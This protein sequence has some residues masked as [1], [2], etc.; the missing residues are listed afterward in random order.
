MVPIV[1]DLLAGGVINYPKNDRF[2]H[3]QVLPSSSVCYLPANPKML[4]ITP[5]ETSFTSLVGTAAAIFSHSTPL[6]LLMLPLSALVRRQTFEYFIYKLK[7][8]WIQQLNLFATL[9]QDVVDRSLTWLI[10]IFIMSTSYEK[11]TLVY[12]KERK[13]RRTQWG[14]I[15]S[16][17]S[18][19]N[20][21][22]LC[23]WIY[24]LQWIISLSVESWDKICMWIKQSCI[25]R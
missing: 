9:W 14:C 13:W 3:P 5:Q 22:L 24:P 2:G 6:L 4:H 19:H 12:F 11:G 1:Q 18:M 7:F 15:C 16:P 10:D 17:D 25:S 21:R 23:N 20:C 8:W